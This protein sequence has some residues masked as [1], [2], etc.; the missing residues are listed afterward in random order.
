[1][2]DKAW[3]VGGTDHPNC[4]PNDAGEFYEFDLSDNAWTTRTSRSDYL[5]G[6]NGGGSAYDDVYVWG[7]HAPAYDSKKHTKWD[8]VGLVWINVMSLPHNVSYGSFLPMAGYMFTGKGLKYDW[9]N[10]A[11]KGDISTYKASQAYF[12]IGVYLYYCGEMD[13]TTLTSH[14][15]D[16]DSQ[17]WSAITDMLWAAY[18][19]SGTSDGTYGY[20]VCG[21]K[22]GSYY[23]RNDR[24]D[25]AGNNWLQRTDAGAPSRAPGTYELNGKAYIF[26]GYNCPGG[27][28][29][30][31]YH[32]EYDNAGDSWTSKASYPV[33]LNSQIGIAPPA[34]KSP[35]KPTGLSVS[36]T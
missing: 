12:R 35:N 17:V 20:V 29:A 8:T 26:G 23:G 36:N 19:R 9:V 21:Q 11:W 34:N 15:Y 31:T 30:T 32:G 1:M 22:S 33:A 10:N 27:C 5:C 4:R 13:E 2:G 25:P 6:G 18:A 16:T 24:Y 7:G 28:C 3:G 14:K